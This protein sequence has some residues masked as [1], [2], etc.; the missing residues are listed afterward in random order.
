M[1]SDGLALLRSCAALDEVL[2]QKV[3]REVL[4]VVLG[5]AELPRDL[6]PAVAHLLVQA[7]QLRFFFFGPGAA[8]HVVAQVVEP[9][10]PALLA[11]A[12]LE[13]R[14]DVGPCR[15]H[16]VV[17]GEVNETKRNETKRMMSL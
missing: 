4:H 16:V 5:A 1:P 10:L 6:C 17:Q 14:R 3:V 15:C 11:A 9:P 13:L 12:P 2:L 8:L 7:S